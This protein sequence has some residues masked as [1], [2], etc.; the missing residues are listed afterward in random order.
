M[1][2][3]TDSSKTETANNWKLA[4]YLIKELWVSVSNVPLNKLWV[5]RYMV[6]IGRNRFFLFPIND[7]HFISIQVS[8]MYV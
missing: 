3:A 8:D 2:I 6:L 5:K 1:E 7:L 4:L